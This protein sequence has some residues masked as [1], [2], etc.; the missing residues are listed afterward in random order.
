M[1]DTLRELQA[2]VTMYYGIPRVDIDPD[3]ALQELGIDAVGLEELI[4]A[5]EDKYKI[6]VSMAVDEHHN[7]NTSG[8]NV[9]DQTLRAFAGWVDQLLCGGPAN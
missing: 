1:A 6:V 9:K 4:V 2:M 3:C 5:V 7:I 8:R